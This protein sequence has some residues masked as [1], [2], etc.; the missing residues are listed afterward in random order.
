MT[1][2]R[3]GKGRGRKITSFMTERE[4]K[5]GRRNK[6]EMTFLFIARRG[7]EKRRKEEGGIIPI[8]SCLGKK[9][10]RKGSEGCSNESAH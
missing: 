3:G 8:P 5:K 7:G 10:K 9:K 6:R 4:K 2:K 1:T